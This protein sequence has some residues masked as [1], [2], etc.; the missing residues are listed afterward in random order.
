MPYA[1]AAS[2]RRSIHPRQLS[3]SRSH[4]NARRV[5]GRRQ[6]VSVEIA[7]DVESATPGPYSIVVATDHE[8]LREI[9]YWRDILAKIADDID[10]TA[11]RE[12][13]V[14]RRRWFDSRSRRIRELLAEPVPPG[15][16]Q[17]T[18]TIGRS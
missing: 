9:A 3:Q 14:K 4:W 5:T 12:D 2:M 6:Q 17:L 13:D 8:R 1:V 11:A 16:S 7:L 10:A 15:W 18:S